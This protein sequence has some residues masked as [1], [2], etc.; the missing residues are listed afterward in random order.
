M[1]RSQTIEISGKRKPDLSRVSLRLSHSSLYR[2]AVSLQVIDRSVFVVLNSAPQSPEAYQA[3]PTSLPSASNALSEE[4]IHPI[5]MPG[6][7]ALG[8]LVNR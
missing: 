2:K 6:I 8:G 1:C 5:R 7:L 4:R 3:K